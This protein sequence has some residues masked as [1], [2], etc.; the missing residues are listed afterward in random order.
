[1]GVGR[2]K[3]ILLQKLIKEKWIFKKFLDAQ[4]IEFLT[5]ESTSIK[6]LVPQGLL[7]NISYLQQPVTLLGLCHQKQLSRWASALQT[8]MSHNYTLQ[9]PVTFSAKPKMKALYTKF[10]AGEI[11]HLPQCKQVP[12]LV[13]WKPIIMYF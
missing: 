3:Q 11:D 12:I 2:Q 5:L 4:G 1:M 7:P 10:Q 6:W 9:C 13:L 8:D